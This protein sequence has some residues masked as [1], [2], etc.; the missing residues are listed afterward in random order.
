MA[1][2]QTQS[3]SMPFA[4]RLKL[5]AIMFLQFMIMPIW[6]NTFIPYIQTLEGGGRLTVWCGMLMGFGML[7][8][9][10]L[11]MFADRLFNAE[12]VLAVCNLTCAAL[13]GSCYFISSPVKLFAVMLA[14]TIIYMPSW[15]LVSALA[16]SN[17]TPASF[18]HIRVFG[19]LGWIF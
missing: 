8:S 16:M 3:L 15:S 12:K 2:N 9:P 7:A 19:S 1:S 4:L 17:A 18:P 5:S 13:L 6:F 11:C 14:V 10:V